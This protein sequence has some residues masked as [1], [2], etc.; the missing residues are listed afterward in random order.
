VEP[1]V[2]AALVRWASEERAA[3][4]GSFTHMDSRGILARAREAGIA[5]VRIIDG[6]E[7]EWWVEMRT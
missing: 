3:N 5:H 7:F 4:P 2:L 1:D 6:G